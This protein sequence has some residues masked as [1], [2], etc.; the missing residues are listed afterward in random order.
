[1][2]HLRPREKTHMAK[3]YYNTTTIQSVTNVLVVAVVVSNTIN[4]W[5]ISLQ[6]KNAVNPNVKNDPYTNSVVDPTHNKPLYINL[7][8]TKKLVA[9]EKNTNKLK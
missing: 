8:F 2:V 6:A 4:S 3:L 1:M 9:H 5:T 7:L